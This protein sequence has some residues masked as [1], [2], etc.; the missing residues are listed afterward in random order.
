MPLFERQNYKVV[1]EDSQRKRE[2][3]TFAGFTPQ[4]AIWVRAGPD[5]H[6]NPGVSSGAPTWMQ[7]PKQVGCAPLVSQIIIRKLDGRCS[8]QDSIQWT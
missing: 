6:Q 1:W 7:G 2:I 8:S 4:M 3:E 5:Q